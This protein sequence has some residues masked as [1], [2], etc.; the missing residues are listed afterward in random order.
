MPVHITLASGLDLPDSELLK[1]RSVILDP[2]KLAV[3]LV[4]LRLVEA[5]SKAAA[6]IMIIAR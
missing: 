4:G 1:R 6:L 2:H 5:Y 3:G